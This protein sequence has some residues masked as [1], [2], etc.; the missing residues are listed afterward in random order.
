[1]NWEWLE[2]GLSTHAMHTP[3]ASNV[4][5]EDQIHCWNDSSFTLFVWRIYI[6]KSMR[7]VPEWE[8]QQPKKG[9]K[10]EKTTTA[11]EE[12]DTQYFGTDSTIQF[13]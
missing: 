7:K 2:L 4:M 5:E 8:Q 12:T 10:K 13:A 11:A 3:Y 6:D 1:M 9:G